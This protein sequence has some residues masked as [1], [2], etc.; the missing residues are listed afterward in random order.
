MARAAGI[1]YSN[2]TAAATMRLP[3]LFIFSAVAL[4][5][6]PALSQQKPRA[7]DL[8]IPF[9]GA[10]GPLNA[11]TDVRG[12]EVGQ[13]TIIKGDGR[14]EPGKGPVRTGVTTVFPRGKQSSDPVMAAWS[15]LNGNGE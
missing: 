11:I 1:A 14:L 6:A 4:L 8:G 2:L 5:P 9:S 7:R 3:F 13:V 12:V 10:P 15:T